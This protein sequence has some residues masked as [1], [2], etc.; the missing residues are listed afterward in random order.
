MLPRRDVI[1]VSGQDPSKDIRTFR[2]NSGI[3]SVILLHL[4]SDSVCHDVPCLNITFVS[5]G[6]IP[7]SSNP[8]NKSI[9]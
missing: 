1:S 8:T 7:E 6:Q 5:N 3:A 9:C 4:S 2:A